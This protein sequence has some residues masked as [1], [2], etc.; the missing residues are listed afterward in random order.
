MI[1]ISKLVFSVESWYTLGAIQQS[2]L[3]GLAVVPFR[4]HFLPPLIRKGGDGLVTY[5]AL[6]Q[7]TLLIITIVSLFWDNRK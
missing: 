1:F 5:E 4:G 2:G 3:L 7:F 6:F